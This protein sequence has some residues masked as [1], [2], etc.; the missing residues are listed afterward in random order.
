MSNFNGRETAAEVNLVGLP[1]SSA[2][3]PHKVKRWWILRRGME[4]GMKKRAKK[5]EFIVNAQG[6]IRNYL[7]LF[8]KMC[9]NTTC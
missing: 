2:R 1:P 3:A 6:N 9:K 7:A 5:S 8:K 4:E